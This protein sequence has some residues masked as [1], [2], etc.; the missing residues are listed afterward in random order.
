MLA[1]PT[2][3]RV[4]LTRLRR[5]VGDRLASRPYRLVGGGGADFLDV[6]AALRADDPHGALAGY[7]GPLLPSSEAPGV[8]AQRNWLDTRL[9]AAV[10]ACAD[11]EL[12]RGWADRH[13]F[14]DLRIWERLAGLAPYPSAHRTV[15]AERIREL[16][17][18]YGLPTDA[19]F[20]QRPR[21]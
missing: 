13:G 9:R 12:V 18:E 20:V 4:E 11:P 16:R 14:D 10:L 1:N 7:H 6:A 19:T 2:T 17:S 15:A 21:I 3:L 5:V 8:I